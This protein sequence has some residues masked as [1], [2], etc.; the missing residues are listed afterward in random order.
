MHPAYKESKLVSQAATAS[1]LI[2]T[3]SSQISGMLQSGAENFTQ[4]TQPT[5]KPLTFT[6]VTHDRVRKINSLTQGAAGLSAKTVGQVS[7]YAQNLGATM[8]RRGKGKGV[9]RDGRPVEGYRPGILNKSLIAFSTVADGIDQGARNL[10]TSSSVAAST[11]VGHRYG[12]EA[13]EIARQLGGGVK[14][15][16]LVYVDAA[17]VSR[18]AVVKSV[19]KGM[20][21]GR[22]KGGG[23]LVVGGDA[24]LMATAP[25]QGGTQNFGS[26]G[27]TAG[28]GAAGPAGTTQ[29]GFGNA[30]PPAYGAG[31]GEPIGGT[32]RQG[33]DADVKRYS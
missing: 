28:L 27:S 12:S 19:A 3:T 1:R 5:Q 16:G 18:K 29:V 7:K 20:V 32:A 24:S 33:Q 8:A 30:A 25:Q 4:K 23:D 2:V 14:N 11:V 22:V 6:P 13:G 15:V 26:S 9:D 17:G 21:L 10:L 31:I